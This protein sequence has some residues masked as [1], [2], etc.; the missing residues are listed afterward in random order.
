MLTH[1][2]ADMC[3]CQSRDIGDLKRARKGM[4]E[5]MVKMDEGLRLF[6]SDGEGPFVEGETKHI[7]LTLLDSSSSLP[8]QTVS[9]HSA[10]HLL[11]LIPCQCIQHGICSLS[12]HV[13]A[14]SMASAPS[15][16]MSMHPAWHL[17]P[18]I[19][20]THICRDFHTHSSARV[21]CFQMFLE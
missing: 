11:P 18:L 17:L 1:S 19:Q 3:L 8:S 14:S 5:A 16:T 20:W 15:H 10:W 13:N 4:C 6:G 9:M 2:L 7:S 12:Y 21:D